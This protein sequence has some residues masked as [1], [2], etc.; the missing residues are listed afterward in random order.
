MRVFI[1]MAIVVA[2]FTLGSANVRAEETNAALAFYVVS[3]QKIDGGTFIN[4]TNYPNLGYVA[5]KPDFVVTK[6]DAVEQQKNPVLAITIHLQAEESKRFGLFTE[7]LV[8]KRLLV[9]FGGKP[10]IAPTVRTRISGG[11]LTITFPD[12]ASL[13]SA[14]HDLKQLIIKSPP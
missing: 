12:E 11:H 5:A 10:L 6:L 14:E 1:Y 8:G 7:N 2:S 3:E 4:T 13:A 9:M